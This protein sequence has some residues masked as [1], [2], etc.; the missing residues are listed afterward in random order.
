MPTTVT[1]GQDESLATSS[2]LQ[3]QVDSSEALGAG[4][5]PTS[6]G[7]KDSGYSD[8]GQSSDAR[9]EQFKTHFNILNFKINT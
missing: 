8:T 2:K 7:L 5:Q 9:Y 6:L 4:E 3:T 1:A